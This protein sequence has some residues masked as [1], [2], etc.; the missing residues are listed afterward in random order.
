MSNHAQNERDRWGGRD[1]GYQSPE[2]RIAE[3]NEAEASQSKIT[4]LDE[5]FATRKRYGRDTEVYRE[6]SEDFGFDEECLDHQPVAIHRYDD[7]NYGAYGGVW[8]VEFD[9]RYW[10]SIA[11]IEQS[12]PIDNPETAF[13]FIA[14]SVFYHCYKED[15]E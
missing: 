6:I 11:S 12:Y 14:Q 7:P 2:E 3:A 15:K 1:H 4:T 5:L 13:I 8:F 10:L 9:D